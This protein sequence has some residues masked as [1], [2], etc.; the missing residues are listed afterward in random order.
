[1]RVLVIRPEPDATRTATLLREWGH[2]ALVAPVLRTEIL[3]SDLPEAADLVVLTS[4]NAVRALE[5]R[6]ELARLADIP[7]VA[8]GEATATAARAAGFRSVVSADGRAAD[9]ARVVARLGLPGGARVFYPAA[10][11]RADPLEARLE[12]LGLTVALVPVYRTVAVT[13]WPQAAVDEIDA[14]AVDVVQ[15]MSRRSGVVLLDLVRRYGIQSAARRISLHAISSDAVTPDL[16][17]AFASVTIATMPNLDGL[18]ACLA[19]SGHG[20]SNMR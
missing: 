20:P 4:G 1:M 12:A 18:V 13:D 17:A 15:V 3:P 6:A 8:V 16:A 10:Q 14:G 11:E 19:P 2:Q 7:A 9:V 5:G